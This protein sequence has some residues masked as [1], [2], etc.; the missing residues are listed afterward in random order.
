MANTSTNNDINLDEIIRIVQHGSAWR[1]VQSMIEKGV[2]SVYENM[3]DAYK[4]KK[5]KVVLMSDV[6]RKEEAL[7]QLFT[8][9]ER[10]PKQLALLNTF[11][12]LEKT[13]PVVFQKA[14]LERAGTS[15]AILQSLC[16]K[17][18][19]RIDTVDV[20]RLSFL[21]T[22]DTLTNTLNQ[23]QAQ[24]FT[25]VQLGFDQNKPVLLQGITGS[26]KT[27]VYVACIEKIRAQGRQVL[28][29]VPE[30]A[31]TAQ[32]VR[33]L[34]AYLGDGV[35]IYHSRF[36]QNERV[37]VWNKVNS[38][39]L[40]I[41]IGARSA[42]FLPFNDLGLVIV[43]EEHDGSYKQHDPAP[44]YHARDAAIMLAHQNNASVLLG[45]A[46]PSVETLFN[47][48]QGKYHLVQLVKRFGQAML[49]AVQVIDMKEATR[50][51]QVRGMFSNVLLQGIQTALAQKQQVIL[52]QNRRGY[53]P[54]CMCTS[55]GWVPQCKHCDVSMTYHKSTDQ[56]HCH[57]CG[58]RTPYI[59]ICPACG[60]NHI[61]AKSFGTE[62]V[63]DDIQALFPNARVQRFDGD[64]LRNKNKYQ[65]II[66]QFE[67]G[68]LDILVGTQMVVKGLDFDRV[69]L[70]GVL[71]ADGLL[72]SPDFRVNERVFQ[73]LEQVAG[74]AGRKDILGKVMIQAYRID[75]PVLQWVLHHDY[76]GF[77]S[78]ELPLRKAFQYPPYTRLIR[79]TFRHKKPE[80]VA[81]AAKQFVAQLPALA[82]VALFGPAEPPV[83]RIRNF[84]LQVVMF[85]ISRDSRHLNHI[86]SVLLQQAAELTAQKKY[87][88]VYIT[89]DV[90]PM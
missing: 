26:G 13:E 20:D 70:V 83:S 6:Y 28:F 81:D 65:E 54:F 82:E 9:L 4:P 89:L 56:L 45:S 43:D 60:G 84:Y 8:E 90:D 53:S 41:V 31:L 21:Y 76:R 58:S 5:E 47:C 80:V 3:Q 1:V 33:K 64:T 34:R 16:E 72:S 23:E 10:A 35:G 17:A 88:Q 52:F 48:E 75:H 71:S 2:V 42:L 46:T 87:R 24:A 19:F 18:I 63:E 74:R 39:E 59:R 22:G 68:Q 51:K 55:C 61:I 44:R 25:S 15:A 11:L 27:H 32:L 57:Y 30:I 37:E 36:N 67:K 7:K 50:D 62:K 69:S 73:L 77:Y 38:G 49:P 85:K 86:K 66:K 12:Y 29:L 78:A 79:F 40:S 14:L